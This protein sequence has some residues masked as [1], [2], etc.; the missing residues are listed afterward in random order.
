MMDEPAEVLSIGSVV[1]GSSH[2]NRPWRDAVNR[3]MNR[4]AEARSSAVSPL[5][6]NVVYQIPGK[7]LQPEFEGVRTGSFRK[8]DSLLLVQ[9]ALPEAVPDDV[10][11]D[12]L[13]RLKDAVDEAE[14]WAKQRR[15]A[16]DLR[17]IKQIVES[18]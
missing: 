1:G 6:V 11:A 9:V 5:N 18:L 7:I 8:K 12:V 15:V 10:D 17:V 3:L 13:Q 2:L 4:V 16:D 14:V